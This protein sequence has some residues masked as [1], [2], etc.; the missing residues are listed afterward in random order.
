[1]APAD[2]GE[3]GRSFSDY[4]NMISE[5]AKYYRGGHG[6]ILETSDR[7]PTDVMS[8]AD[9]EKFDR[10]Q[11]D[12]LMEVARDFP[13]DG[14]DEEL[15]SFASEHIG[16]RFWKGFRQFCAAGRV[17]N[18]Y[19]S[20]LW[21]LQHDHR[22]GN[23]NTC[24]ERVLLAIAH[25]K[26]QI[27]NSLTTY[28]GENVEVINGQLHS[29]QATGDK[30]PAKEDGDSRKPVMRHMVTPCAYCR[31][32]IC[33]HNPDCMVIMP[34]GVLKPGNNTM[35]LP[36]FMLYPDENL[37]KADDPL[38]QRLWQE[39]KTKLLEARRK[40]KE[41]FKELA[42]KYPLTEQDIEMLKGAEENIN[43]HPQTNKPFVLIRGRTVT[44]RVVEM[45]GDIAMPA[46]P[47]DLS[48][49]DYPRNEVEV[50]FVDEALEEPPVRGSS[51][52]P[53]HSLNVF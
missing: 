23:T 5:V 13:I 6:P 2:R 53:P 48:Y 4:I 40:Q 34:A 11:E 36:A 27:I 15:K 43:Q 25:R 45:D 20:P 26:K 16:A 14:E 22:L 19:G 50:L 28:R 12:F 46:D 30:K 41:Y 8:D 52:A 29:L 49:V 31:E 42:K 47:A 33:R 37:F 7:R 9:F 17:L 39:G 18:S 32:G 38:A 21:S 3:G 24:A 35:K 1:M 51:P 10:H 44:D